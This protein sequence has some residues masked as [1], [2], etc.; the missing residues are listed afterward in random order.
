[1]ERQWGNFVGRGGGE[2]GARAG[3]NG[4]L[5]SILTPLLRAELRTPLPYPCAGQADTW[6]NDS[7]VSTLFRPDAG[8]SGRGS[9]ER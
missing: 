5:L 4:V 8:C 9:R 3:A 6:M 1:M 7:G 2:V